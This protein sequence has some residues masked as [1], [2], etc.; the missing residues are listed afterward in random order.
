MSAAIREMAGTDDSLNFPFAGGTDRAIARAALD[1]AGAA[2][3]D[4]AIE[5]MIAR[6]LTHLPGALADNPRYRVLG[7]V[8]QLLDALEG[9]PGYAIGLGTGNV[10]AGAR[11]KLAHG[12]ISRRFAFGGYGC[13]HEERPKLIAAGADRGAARLGVPARECRVIVI[14]DTDRDVSAALAIGAECIGVGT[15]PFTPAQLRAAGAVSAFDDLEA[16]GVLD[17]LLPA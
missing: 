16:P 4:A 14:G 5:A 3:D 8:G 11:A 13:D 9:R 2:A 12:G 1:G 17:A 7:G 6:Y 10:E 15:G